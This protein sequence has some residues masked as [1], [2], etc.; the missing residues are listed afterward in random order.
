VKRDV[1]FLDIL[2]LLKKRWWILVLSAILVAGIAFVYSEVSYKPT[3][4]TNVS[5]YVKSDVQSSEGSSANDDVSAAT[6]ALRVVKDYMEIL[7]AEEFMEIVS[8]DYEAKYPTAWKNQSYSSKWLSNSVS[9]SHVENTSI[10]TVSI[11][12][13]NAA[14][15]YRLGA[16]FEEKA[17]KHINDITGKDVIKVFDKARLAT[18]PSNDMNLVRNTV[19]GALIGVIISFLLVFLIDI[20]DIRIKKEEDIINNYPIP[21][22]GTIPNFEMA[23][24]KK[25]GY[26]Y[27][28]GKK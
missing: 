16:I 14:D 9:F 11:T 28:Y 4:T 18:S 19:M 8:K 24:K 7:K 15:S 23:Q 6:W 2:Q 25:K 3:Y 13:K 20:T 1:N 12:T 5:I 22:L 27:G 21:L 10:F 17:V 26:G